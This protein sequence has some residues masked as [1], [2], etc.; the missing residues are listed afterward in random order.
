M[1]RAA[2]IAAAPVMSSGDLRASAHMGARGFWEPH[3]TGVLPGLPWQASFGRR[4]GPA[5][6]LG[7]D[8]ASVL[9]ELGAA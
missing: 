5:P 6:G 8:T 4:N 2:G 3:G 9:A 7:A 1:L